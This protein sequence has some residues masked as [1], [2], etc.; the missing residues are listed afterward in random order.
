MFYISTHSAPGLNRV[1]TF[2]KVKVR[3]RNPIREHEAT[4]QI[5]IDFHLKTE[6]SRVLKW[7]IK[8]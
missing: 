5:A 1:V 4:A 7:V 2:N 6:P 3:H 8:V